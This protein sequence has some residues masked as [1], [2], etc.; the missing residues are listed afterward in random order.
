MPT[1]ATPVSPSVNL[2]QEKLVGVYLREV[3]TGLTKLVV[4]CLID[5]NDGDPV[6]SQLWSD[7][8]ITSTAQPPAGGFAAEPLGIATG[9]IVDNSLIL[10]PRDSCGYV[11]PVIRLRGEGTLATNAAV[12]EFI[13]DP[14][15]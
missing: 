2:G 5:G 7:V 12:F 10:F 14:H 11:L 9:E 13:T 8:L 1:G 15:S 6:A 4:Q 3:G